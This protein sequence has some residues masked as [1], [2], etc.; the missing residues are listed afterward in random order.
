MKDIKDNI[1]IKAA[2]NIAASCVLFL[3]AIVILE[4]YTSKKNICKGNYSKISIIYVNNN[5]NKSK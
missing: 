2:I 3:P 4:Q 5:Y 1:K